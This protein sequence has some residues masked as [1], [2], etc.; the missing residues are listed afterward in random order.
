MFVKCKNTGGAAVVYNTHKTTSAQVH[1]ARGGRVKRW[2]W[3][4]LSVPG[5]P[6]NLG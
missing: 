4:K 5:R 6:T 3:V 2:C 1:G